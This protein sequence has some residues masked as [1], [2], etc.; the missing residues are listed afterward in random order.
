MAFSFAKEK[1]REFER[2][3]DYFRLFYSKK[4]VKDIRTQFLIFI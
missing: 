4:I 2:H 3:A 1:K